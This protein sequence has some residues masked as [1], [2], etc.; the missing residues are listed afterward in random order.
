MTTQ[1]LFRYEL[2]RTLWLLLAPML[3]SCGTPTSPPTSSPMRPGILK[4]EFIYETA[5]FPSCHASTIAETRNGFAAAWFGGTAE[6]NPDVGIWVARTENEKWTTP[7]E[8]ASGVGFATN[9][10]PCW[11]PVLFQPKAGPLLLFYKV[12]PSP[13]KW[14][15]MLIT[16]HDGGKSWSTPRRLPEKILGPIKNKPVQLSNGD[17]LCPTSSEDAGW[18][19]HFERSSDLGQ[20]WSS[21]APPPD[22]AAGKPIDAIQP[23]IL[24]H[25]NK[26]LQALGRTRNGKIFSTWSQDEGKTW[27]ALTLTEL[28]NPSAGTDAVTLKDGRHLLVCNPV[29]KGRSPLIL[30]QSRD[31]KKWESVLVLEEEPGKEFSYPAI[32]QSNDGLV[33]ITYTWQRKRIKHVVVDPKKLTRCDFANGEWPQS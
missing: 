13:S 14:W 9:R 21:V 18:R 11:N 4:A 26:T 7:V 15:G 5:P 31:G 17:L 27:S 29:S 12:G 23:S 22:E 33:H 24:F 3:C 25:G 1:F 16:S 28:P 8:V 2:S 30:A 32:I 19:V 20:T 6:R 10:L